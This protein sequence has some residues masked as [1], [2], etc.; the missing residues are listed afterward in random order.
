MARRRFGGHTSSVSH[1]EW[2]TADSLQNN[3]DIAEQVVVLGNVALV[4]LVPNTLLRIR[5]TVFA[6]LD[7]GAVDE[8]AMIAFGITIVKTPAFTAGAASVPS[9]VTEADA[10][11]LWQGYISLSSLAEAAIAPNF[12]AGNV[13]IDSKAMRKLSTGDSIIM[14]GEVYE[15]LDQTGSFDFGYLM[16]ILSGN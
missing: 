3:I 6:Q 1:K 11:W 7:A 9:P 2:S 14:V 16:R 12:L 15:S 4:A 5:G 13:E 8:K 10:D